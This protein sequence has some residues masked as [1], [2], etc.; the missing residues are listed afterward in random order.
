MPPLLTVAIEGLALDH[1]PPGVASVS[2]M[3]PPTFTLVGPLMLLTAGNDWTVTF[4]VVVA[5]AV[6]SDICIV[7]ASAPLYPVDGL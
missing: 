5:V 3:F 6:P 1:V 7:N 4:T 2:T